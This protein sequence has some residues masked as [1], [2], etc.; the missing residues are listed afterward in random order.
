MQQYTTYFDAAQFRA[1]CLLIY[2]F[3][4]RH[5]RRRR[6][7]G[8]GH[9]T[10]ATMIRITLLAFRYNL[11]Q[12]LLAA[13]FGIHQT[14]VCRIIAWMRGVFLSVLAGY[15]PQPED[16]E[17]VVAD[18][19]AGTDRPDRPVILLV[20]GT[21]VPVSQ[22]QHNP[23]DFSGKH[24]RIGKNIQ[25]LS[26]VRGRL[27][28]ISPILPGSRYDRRALAESGIEGAISH[29]PRL[30]VHAD[31]GYVGTD[32]IVPTKTSKHH[33]L[34]L[35]QRAENREISGIRNAVE[36]AIAG[37]K[38]LDILRSGIRT[39]SPQRETV[40]EEIVSVAIGLCFYRQ[41]TRKA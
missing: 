18:L 15:I 5:P 36:R 38:I 17:Q 22:R 30:L 6:K 35:A 14:T 29:R 13:W 24:H 7:R 19:L 33:P 12:H 39:R 40:I 41:K 25:V 20:D 11:R 32:F 21:L 34:T 27:L 2:R 1:F 28:H 10:I 16:V 4:R 9:L 31:R 37:L 26:D 23:S 8:R 3:L